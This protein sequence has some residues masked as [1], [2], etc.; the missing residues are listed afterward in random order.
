MSH[1]IV[2][3]HTEIDPISTRRSKLRS[4]SAGVVVA[5]ATM[6]AC[7][8]AALAQQTFATPEAAADGL[9]EAAKTASPGFVEKV[10]G[11]GS[12]D[13][14]STG[15][16]DED[17]K[18]LK[19][20]NDAAAEKRTV[21]EKDASTRV[22]EVGTNAFAFPVP[23][24]RKG[25]A[26]IFDVQAGRTELLNRTIGF[27]EFSAIEAC[28]AYVAAQKEYFRLDRDNDE[29]QSYAQ[30]ILSTPGRH[31]GLYWEPET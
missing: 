19:D 13:L 1:H 11:P 10:F 2:S 24:V 16:A 8:G 7:G 25:D 31:D 17:K 20:F 4:F 28:Q 26:W 18:R 6:L 22:L 9:I 21:V 29:V 27:N 15:D 3:H 30:R 12:R 23:I 14:L 5:L